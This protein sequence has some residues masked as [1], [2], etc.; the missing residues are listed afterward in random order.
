M[1]EEMTSTVGCVTE[2]VKFCAANYVLVFF[3]PNVFI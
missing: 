2:K 3:M 1:M